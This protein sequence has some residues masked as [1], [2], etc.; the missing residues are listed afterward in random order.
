MKKI[1]LTIGLIIFTTT[2]FL[3]EVDPC[4]KAF[5]Q[6]FT[7]LSAEYEEDCVNCSGNAMCLNE[8]LLAYNQGII[9]ALRVYS[10]CKEG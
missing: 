7:D 2:V 8:A 10:D 4:D 6:S 5:H 9:N 1:I 3:A